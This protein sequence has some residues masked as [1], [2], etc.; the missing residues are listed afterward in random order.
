MSILKTNQITDLGGN[1][2]ISSDGSGTLTLGSTF[3]N[4]TPAFAVRKTD[5]NQS[6]S[7]ATATKVTFNNE[8][9]D[10]D[11]AFADSKFTVPSGK[12]GVYQ[13]NV[14]IRMGTISADSGMSVFLYLNGSEYT[15]IVVYITDESENPIF[16]GVQA[17][18]LSVGDYVEVYASTNGGGGN[19]F[20]NGCQFTGFKLGA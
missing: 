6:Y 4:N 10:S 15:P 19:F 20:S 7:Q 16:G 5:G 9:L 2:I 14:S 3:P 17:L 8:L 11:N 1:A 18:D 13:F 12:A